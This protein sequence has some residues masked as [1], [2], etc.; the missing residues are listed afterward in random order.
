[1]KECDC[2]GYG[3][4]LC[5]KDLTIFKDLK[6]EEFNKLATGMTC[7]HANKGEYICYEGEVLSKLFLISSGS[8]KI[9]K[10][11]KSGKEQI[12]HIF[13]R[14]DYFGET[15]LFENEGGLSFNAIALTDITICAI[16]S[17]EVDEILKENPNIAFV[18]LKSLTERLKET[19]EFAHTLATNDVQ[20]RIAY[21]L[22]E[23]K[24]K[25]GKIENGDTYIDLPI[26]REEM[27][28]YC[29]ITRETMSRKLSKFEHQGI[30]EVRGNKT[31][32]IK[33]FDEILSIIS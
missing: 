18:V 28:N 21:M 20:V 23:F 10:L 6:E 31:L 7:F 8:V 27:A 2:K 9:S 19:E 3:N 15:S 24:E 22:K 17:F 4:C 26:N 32:I 16:D 30:I 25:Y 11:T 1:M 14:G 13:S 33:D 12:I 29:G 5:S